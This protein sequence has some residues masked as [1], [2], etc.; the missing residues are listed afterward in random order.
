MTGKCNN[1]QNTIAE[2]LIL[3]ML[4]NRSN[5][6]LIWNYVD[7]LGLEC[8]YNVGKITQHPEWLDWV[9]K[10]FESLVNE[11]GT[12]DA[13]D[14]EEYSLDMIAPG[15]ALFAIYHDTHQ[16]KY[17]KV[18][19]LFQLQL[20]KQP[21]TPSGGYWHKGRYTNQMWL[22]GLYMQGLFKAR[23]ACEFLALEKRVAALDDLV[24][25]FSLIY[26]HTFD[27]QTG[28]LFHAWDESKQMPWSDKKT[29]CSP[30]IWGRA[31]GWYCMAL[32]DVA[33]YLM[34][35]GAFQN[36]YEALL[37]LSVSL[38]EAVAQW[39]DASG[40]WWQIMDQGGK[41]YNYLESSCSSMFTYFFLKLSRIAE[42]LPQSTRDRFRKTGIAGYQ[43][44]L[45]DKVTVDS[46]G[47][48]HLDA[49]CRGAGLGK[50]ADNNPYRDGTFVYY[51]AREPIVQDNWQGVVPLTLAAL[52]MEWL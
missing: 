23:Y 28:L 9:L 35:N 22:D 37:V 40:L 30:C 29:G 1:F 13:Y 36:H 6:G 21:R 51:C 45:R 43:G 2:Q 34:Q 31:L 33:E 3:S 48:L 4:H 42:T 27:L 46:E 38:A 17:K 19:D 25:Q 10:K 50:S 12:I 7:G 5:Q 8:L 47:Y 20:E 11:N 41:Q 32:V 39:Q 52:E 16:G 18:L 49:I 44:L 14:L 15:K 24:F 26:T